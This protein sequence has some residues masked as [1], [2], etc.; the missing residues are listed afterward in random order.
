MS[1]DKLVDSNE[2]NGNLSTLANKIREKANVDK[3]LEFP[4]DFIANINS[5]E[6]QQENK[7]F[8]DDNAGAV[9]LEITIPDHI[10]VLGDPMSFGGVNIGKPVSILN[11][12]K[13][14]EIL[15][16]VCRHNS[17]LK[18]V[19]APELKIIKEQVFAGCKS[20]TEV[21]VP[22]LEKI[23]GDSFRECG[24]K[25]L[26]LPNI[27]EIDIEAF[28]LCPNLTK[29]VIN[30]PKDSIPGAPWGATNATVEWTG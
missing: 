22:K 27:Q 1:Y 26:Y 20:L 14:E 24:L 21:I 18:R 12:P 4:N 13:V 30:K 15:P 8:Y 29:I 11:L 2:L 10:T 28:P 5:V 25:E 17:Y 23:I 6:K 3:Q 7:V 19:Y 9:T 16:A